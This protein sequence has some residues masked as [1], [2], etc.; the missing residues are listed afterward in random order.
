MR[1]FFRSLNILHWPM[2][3]KLSL[4]FVFAIVV[5][6][7]LIATITQSGINSIGERNL[8]AYIEDQGV[9]Q[10]QLIVTKLDE[11]HQAINNLVD[12]TVAYDAILKNLTN[13]RFFAA[14]NVRNALQNFVRDNTEF[15]SI[16]LLN[17]EGLVIAHVTGQQ[18]L[19]F[20]LDESQTPAFTQATNAFIQDREQSVVITDNPL[21]IEVTQAVFDVNNTLQG[22]L[23]GTVN[24][25]VVILDNLL[26]N[27][28]AY[29]AYS[30]LVRP[31]QTPIVIAPPANIEQARIAAEASTAVGRANE[32]FT[33][34]ATYTIGKQRDLNVIGRYAPIY[35][36]NDEN[37]VLFAMVTEASADTPTLQA[38][39]YFSGARIFPIG[40]GLLVVLALLVLLFNQLITPSLTNLR[41]AIQAASRGD[42][43]H[44]VDAAERGDEIGAVG[45]A[46]VDMRVQIRNLLDDLEARVAARTRDI[47]AT[48]D[49]SRYAATQHNLQTLLDQVVQLIVER[50]PNIYHAQ[51]FL[52]DS[53]RLYAVLRASTGEPGKQLLA[54]GHRLA[55]GSVSVIGQVIDQ[56]QTIIAR[57]TTTS[58]V[59]RRNEF[60]PDTHAELA[61]PLRVGDQII[62]SLDVQSKFRNAFAADEVSILET[63]ADQIAVAI[64]NARLYQESVRRLEDIERANREATMSTWREY[65]YGQRQRQLLSEAGTST[66]EDLSDLRR[67]AIALGQ[68]VAGEPTSHNTI[69]VAVPI[70]LR[71]QTLG[72]VEWELPLDDMNDNKL[73]LAQEL[74][75]RLA[76][77]LENARL[78]EESQRATERERIVNSIAAK[79][80][81]QTEV[82]EILQTAVREVGQALRAPQVS[83]RLHH[84]NGNG[85]GNGQ[86]G[87]NGSNGSHE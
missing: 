51:I 87:S 29:P 4:G 40:L 20:G 42:F 62:G 48:Q 52:I 15:L 63:M 71:G 27:T 38:S 78:F 23:I 21:T 39:D 22:V 81:P 67:R 75:N 30:Y 11:S 66:G 41:A 16:R 12:S 79:L 19:P 72:A 37:E 17:A 73:Q 69:P 5:P 10:Q 55:V 74:A 18:V 26:F 1:S 47:S 25:D 34:T 54:R 56:K 32:G 57:D 61:I 53:E 43:N 82:S 14:P 83:I 46:F 58:Q 64:E 3:L 33:E 68:I 6:V 24:P 70:Q 59:H 77:S 44:A 80:T 31:G 45:A 65:I 2:W 60:L 35:N 49:I 13:R 8:T 86:N 28:D 85:N 50:F 76:V 84:T 36:P 7:Y 9:R